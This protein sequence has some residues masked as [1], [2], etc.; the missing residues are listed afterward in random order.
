M[1]IVLFFCRFTVASPV[2]GLAGL[3]V[4]PVG[5]CGL[6]FVVSLI[7]RDNL[8]NERTSF[9]GKYYLDC[10]GIGRLAELSG[11]DGEKGVDL[12]EFGD[13]GR[14]IPLKTSKVACLIQIAEGKDDVITNP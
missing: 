12:N 10:T 2:T 11:A 3:A 6:Y 8:T 5:I 4:W 13:V 9:V 14:D 1:S 7:S